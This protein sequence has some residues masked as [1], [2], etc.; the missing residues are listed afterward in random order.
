M[1]NSWWSPTTGLALVP[2]R[3]VQG[4]HTPAKANGVRSWPRANH[5]QTAGLVNVGS[6]KAVAGTRQR[7]SGFSQPRQCGD[8]GFRILV[9]GNPPNFTGPGMP[10][11]IGSI[12]RPPL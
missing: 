4:R 2:R 9:I 5:V 12:S 8:V 1:L 7:Y 11:R 6:Q 10:H 3:P